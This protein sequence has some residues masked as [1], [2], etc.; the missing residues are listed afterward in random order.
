MRGATDGIMRRTDGDIGSRFA[1]ETPFR[2]REGELAQTEKSAD[3]KKVTK[4][5]VKKLDFQSVFE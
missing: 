5:C 1:L 4:L 3:N 2:E